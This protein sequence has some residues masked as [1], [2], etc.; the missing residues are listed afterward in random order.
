M[1]AGK[2]FS[3]VQVEIAETGTYFEAKDKLYNKNGIE[4]FYNRY[5]RCIT[6]E[7]SCQKRILSKQNSF[8]C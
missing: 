1:I 3:T 2:E 7:G 8:L 5:N 6:L 4:I